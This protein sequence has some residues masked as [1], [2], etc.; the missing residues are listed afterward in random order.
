MKRTPGRLVIFA[1]PLRLWLQRF[2]FLLLIALALGLMA[3]GRTEPR[4]IEDLRARIV[5]AAAPMI[6]ALAQPVATFDRAATNIA[7]YFDLHAENARLRAE[8]E[9]LLQ[10]QHAAQ[11]LI[12]ENH[13]LR[14][15][16]HFKAEPNQ[17]FITAR[18]IGSSGGP[19]TRSMIITAG[20]LDGVRKGMAALAP[21]GLIGRV[22]E[23]GAWSARIMLLTDVNS[24]IPVMFSD[25]DGL[26]GTR[27]IMAG[28]NSATP[29]LLYL[30]QDITPAIGTRLVTSGHGGVF[31]PLLPVGVVSQASGGTADVVPSADFAHVGY[32]RLVDFALP[33]GD[34]NPMARE[35]EDAK[36][37][38]R[39]GR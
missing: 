36:Q 5:D 9:R 37:N 39:R 27:A 2:S 30:P 1:L 31:P 10:W 6:S 33:G 21:G 38:P 15:F 32:V 12:E 35:L 17:S 20:S 7:G 19:F 4:A 18:V 13:D 23:V 34:A 3:L 8:N 29:H 16:L 11:A 14:S 22:T 24:R 25:G 28:D 26:Q